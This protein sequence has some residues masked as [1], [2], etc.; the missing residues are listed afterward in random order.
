MGTI[1]FWSRITILVI[2]AS[3]KT[4]KKRFSWSGNWYRRLQKCYKKT[5]FSPFWAPKGY[6][7]VCHRYIGKV[8]KFG[9]FRIIIFRNNCHFPV[10][11]AENA[12]PH[13]GVGLK[14]RCNT[15]LIH[16]EVH[17]CT[18]LVWIL[19]LC[20]SPQ[21]GLKEFWKKEKSPIFDLASCLS[22]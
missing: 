6:G 7:R 16:R 15:A 5:L 19:F 14:L 22:T 11:G 12:P 9:L 10:G 2:L 13:T 17:F 8:T 1:I 20:T 21:Q 18:L 3:K 4:K